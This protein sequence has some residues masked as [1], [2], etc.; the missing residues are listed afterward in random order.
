MARTSARIFLR[1][2]VLGALIMC[3]GPGV[4]A[5]TDEFY[6]RGLEAYR[7]GRYEEA[8]ALFERAEG[9]QPGKTDALLY[10]GKAYIHLQKFP[11]AEKCFR[12]YV[13]N[14]PGAADGYYLLGYVLHR[15]NRPKESLEI[16]TKA[17]SL[18]R[19]TGDDL[20][21]VALNYVLLNDM[22]DATHWLERS[23]ELDPKNADA[24]YYLGRA[25]YTGSRLP[26]A[27]KAYDRVLQL[28]PHNVKAENNIGL[29]YESSAKPEE[30]LA[31]YRQAIEWQQGSER[32]SEQPYLNLGNLLLTMEKTDEALPALEKAVLLAPAN[33]LCHLKLGMAYL[34]LNRP[35]EAR[36]ELEEAV[37]LNPGDAVAHYQLGRYYKQAKKLDEAKAEF[38]RVEEIQTGAAES[39]KVPSQP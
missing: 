2:L 3:L 19:P 10:A 13:A 30:A 16:Y 33:S 12:G 4:S 34:R 20:K 37:R 28:D 1:A 31:A 23:V 25:Y 38:R 39:Q 21:I 14:S 27:R 26:D 36:K 18:T 17:A 15:E 5:Q 22:A 32:P 35:E 6:Q 7:H 11:D 24:W 29:I 8:A 9:E